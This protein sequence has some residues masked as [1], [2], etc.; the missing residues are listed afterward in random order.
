M[1][2][3]RILFTDICDKNCDGC[4]NKYMLDKFINVSINALAT[5]DELIITGGE[6][7]LFKDEL[8]AFIKSI[9]AVNSIAPIYVY[10]ALITSISDLEDVA[11]F[12]DGFSVTLH[13]VEDVEKFVDLGLNKHTFN[14]KVMRLNDFTFS[15]AYL[16]LTGNWIY[17][18]KVWLKDCPIPEFETLLKIQN[19]GVF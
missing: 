10:T 7:M 5:Y 6:P 1:Q 11:A 8:I 16:N 19:Y 15:K 18:E 17:R 14:N 13:S 9:R 3:A 4:V 2:K 12:V